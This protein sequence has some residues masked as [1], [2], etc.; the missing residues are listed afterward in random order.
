MIAPDKFKGTLDA[1]EVAR[2]LAEGWNRGDREADIEEVPVADGGDGTLEAL[3]AALS[4]EIREATVAGPLGAPVEAAYGL[5]PT[6]TGLVGVV[7]MARASGLA[8]LDEGRHDP[9]RA[10]TR[11]TGQLI[12]AA[13]EHGPARVMVC[14]GG[15]ATNDAGAGVAQALGIRLLDEEGMDLPPGGA[16]LDRLAR[17]DMSGLHPSVRDVE[18]V[19]ASDVDNPLT[20]PH[21]AS[22]VY[23]PQKGA[24]PGD[25]AFLDR[26][27]G[28]FA[29]IV[30]RE[31]GI[32]VRDLP[33]AGA[34]GGLGGG[35]VAFLG[36]NLRPGFDLVAEAVGLP[37]RVESADVV[38]TGE[39]RYDRQSE[40]GKAPAGVLRIARE[41][42]KG[43]ALVAGQIQEGSRPDADV[44]YSLAERAG[45]D[46]AMA[47][48]RE[49]LE[50]AGEEVARRFVRGKGE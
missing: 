45:L 14:I 32:D 17:I 16:A 48:P 13:C 36:A 22:A 5:V 35:L 27:L 10:T 24:D 28:H 50:E 1:S 39:G 9:L 20:G 37:G 42:R 41:A 2:A 3:V 26:A 40:R 43:S 47:R 15:S 18:F 25:V 44:V 23:G 11:G 34:A 30:H 8:L 7:E 12:L 49:L 21:G 38:V 33:G 19:V 31:L 29:A 46:E 4:G 6:P